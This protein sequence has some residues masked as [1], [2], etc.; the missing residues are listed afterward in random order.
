MREFK[1][2]ILT[3]SGEA[4][5][6]DVKGVFLRTTDGEVG[7]L[8]G[9]TDYLAGVVACVV[10]LI[11]AEEKSVYAF[12]GGGFFNMA[13]GEATL[14][15]DEFLFADALDGD[16]IE[17]EIREISERL[18]KVTDPEGVQFLKTSLARAEAKKRTLAADEES[19]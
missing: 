10:K 18:A 13:G 11:N 1:L 7:I 6:G 2:G 8:A 19:K 15:A 5:S 16:Q 9:H 4:F 17:N 14:I 12:C 3:P